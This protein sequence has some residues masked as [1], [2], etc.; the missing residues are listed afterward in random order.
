MNGFNYKKA[1]Q[2]L[3]FFARK[4]SNFTLNKMK[5]IKLIWLADRF[6]LRKYGRPIIGDVYFALPYGPVPSTTR[7]IVEE[8]NISLSE[9]ELQYSKDFIENESKYKYKSIKDCDLKVFSKTEVEAFDKIFSTYGGLSQFKLSDISHLFPE[10]K[11]FESRLKQRISSRYPMSYMDFFSNV[12]D[13]FD[14]FQ[15]PEDM[16]EISK[17]LFKMKKE[18]SFE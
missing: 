5:A 17:E 18:F 6:H 13:G 8:N 9:E 2:A 4:S 12:N 14:L 3:N 16:L 7:D 11:R 1:V 10:W 15:D